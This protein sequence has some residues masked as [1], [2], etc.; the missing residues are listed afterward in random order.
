MEHTEE[1]YSTPWRIELTHNK[2]DYDITTPF[3]YYIIAQHVLEP[4]A[5]YIVKAVNNHERL[6]KALKG[7]V[8]AYEHLYA[9]TWEPRYWKKAKQALAEL[10]E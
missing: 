3:G 5:H 6:V 1:H 7:L 4:N 9:D 10:E 8:D 2:V